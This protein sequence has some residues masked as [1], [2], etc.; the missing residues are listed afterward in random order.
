M[1][2]RGGGGLVLLN[3][4]RHGAHERSRVGV[5]S[6]CEACPAAFFAGNM[7]SASLILRTMSVCMLKQGSCTHTVE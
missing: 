3:T 5:L 6:L 1:Y 2:Q 7:A 4:P